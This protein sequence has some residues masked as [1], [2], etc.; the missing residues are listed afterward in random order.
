MG[1]NSNLGDLSLLYLLSDWHISAIA[2]RIAS[3][4]FF[5]M[6]HLLLKHKL[7]EDWF[8]LKIIYSLLGIP[9]NYFLEIVKNACFTLKLYIFKAH[10]THLL[11]GNIRK[12]SVNM[13]NLWAVIQNSS[14]S[15]ESK[16]SKPVINSHK[17]KSNYRICLCSL[18]VTQQNLPC[19]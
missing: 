5:N 7:C 9:E 4:S 10:K 17:P 1:V 8:L 18:D 2:L 19:I 15:N 11:I 13:Y 16:Q 14:L 3:K 12:V 6:P